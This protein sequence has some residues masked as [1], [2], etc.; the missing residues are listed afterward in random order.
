MARDKCPQCGYEIEESVYMRCP[1]CH[2]ILFKKCSECDECN[3]FKKCNP[4]KAKKDV[5]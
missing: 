2:K 4:E 3:L 5:G 1:R